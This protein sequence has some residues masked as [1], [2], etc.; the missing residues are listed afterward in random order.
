MCFSATASF[1]A[2]IMLASI[3]TIS[4]IKAKTPSLKVLAIIP[5]IFSMQQFSEGWV[6]LSLTKEGFASW[7]TPSMYLFL[8]FAEVTWPICISFSMFLLETNKN[9]KKIL[10]IIFYVSISLS[11]ILAYSLY[12][13][14]ADAKVMGNHIMYTIDTT[15]SF[16]AITNMVY[17][18]TAVIP[19]FLSTLKKAW[20]IGVVLIV[21]YIIAKVFYADYIISIWCYF[22]TIIS[23]IILLI[24][25]KNKDDIKVFTFN[26]LNIL[27]IKKF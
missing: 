1:G 26:K 19:P 7:K 24:D 15:D 21:S 4:I 16:K 22:A 6:W 25:W 5:F 17:I 12:Y 13:F 2:S 23:V 9:R 20:W 11:S 8:F 10:R 3:G 18:L 27:R 14:T